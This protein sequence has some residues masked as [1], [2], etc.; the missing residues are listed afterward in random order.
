MKLEDQLS[1][2]EPS[3]R[4]KELKV[5][6]ESLWYW[7]KT[8]NNKWQLALEDGTATD[9]GGKSTFHHGYRF[10][11][12][13]KLYS[14]FTVAELGEMMPK[15]ANGFELRCIKLAGYKDNKWQVAYWE[16]SHEDEVRFEEYVGT[17][18]DARAKMLIHLVKEGVVKP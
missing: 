5:K 12:S 11:L 8:R 1:S 16:I 6:Q 15:E 9:D 4:L 13:K 17:E 14:A 18:A 10:D 7:Y 2:L 3:K